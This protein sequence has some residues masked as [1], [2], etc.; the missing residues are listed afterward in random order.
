MR[1]TRDDIAAAALACVARDGFAVSLRTVAAEAGVS[2]ALIVHHF[3]SKQGLLDALEDHVLGIAE[4]KLRLL[5]HEGPGAAI[6]YVATLME[7][8]AVPRYLARVLTEGG[9]RAKRLFES[10]VDVTEKGIGPLD[11]A[12]PRLAAA[13]LVTHALGLMVMTDHVAGATGVHPY[14]GD[15]IHRFLVAALDVYGGR[16]LPLLPS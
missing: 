5:D 2:A 9:D 15:E 10:F 3:G 1:S 6:A 14:R 11:L 12:E 16:L 13:L 8:G 4:E 7:D